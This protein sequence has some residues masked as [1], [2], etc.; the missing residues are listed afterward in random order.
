M[1]KGRHFRTVLSVVLAV[2]TAIGSMPA[3]VCACPTQQ[4]KLTCEAV[5]PVT[6]ESPSASAC[7]SSCTMKCCEASAAKKPDP[8]PKTC[9]CFTC[10]CES[11][12]SQ[13]H[14]SVPPPAL[15]DSRSLEFAAAPPAPPFF[16]TVSTTAFPRT[17]ET[18]SV[19]PPID[20]ITT[21]S[22]L[23]C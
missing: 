12:D 6:C 15:I 8:T 4:T 5:S 9:Q 14:D 19:P 11:K 18:R 2:S 3:K 22:R 23:T 20:L 16:L 13:P 7:C 1:L 10:R 17:G 21:L